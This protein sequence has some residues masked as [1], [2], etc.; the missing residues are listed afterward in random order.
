MHFSKPFKY[1][2]PFNID[3]ASP[4][5]LASPS[6]E[7]VATL[8]RSSILVR[9]AASLDIVRTIKLPSDLAG[10]AI[11]TSFLW[12]PSSTRVLVA[13]ADQVHVF[14]LS[15]GGFHGRAQVPH[16]LGTKPAL[17]C[18]GATDDEVCVFSP[19][20]L[21]LSIINFA[22]SKAVEIS[23]PKFFGV[24]SASRGFSFRPASR[25]LALLTRVAG[26][27]L[28]SIHGA[29][30]REM[31]RSWYPDTVDAQGLAW[32]PDG[33]W[34]IVWD[35]PAHGTR[36]LFHTPDG[37]VFKEWRGAH[38]QPEADDMNQYGP[39]VRSLASSPNSLYVAVA[40][41]ANR[42]C[43]LNNRLGEEARLHHTHIVE[44]KET[45]QIWQEQ[46]AP[47]AGLGL[48]A[49]VPPFIK[50]TQAVSPPGL[51]SSSPSDGRSGCSLI[52]FDSSSTLLASR[53]EEAPSTIWIW[54]IPTRELRAVLMFH[55]NITKAEWHP[56]L[57]E[58]LLVRCEGE[59]YSGI[60]FVWDPLSDGP[61]PIDFLPHLS[62]KRLAGRT[63]VSW[64]KTVEEPAVL[65]LT[66]H[67]E[68]ILT[69]LADGDGGAKRL[70]WA[71]QN[72]PTTDIITT[73][74]GPDDG[75]STDMDGG[76]SELDD[77]FHFKKSP[78]T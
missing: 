26:K 41:G 15:A 12:S 73:D 42:I 69:S 74:D 76:V 43:I 58:L 68:C 18:F 13:L 46:A 16:P 75:Y 21:K 24:T 30:T 14:S 36:V 78:I 1:I 66:D 35:S 67:Q 50:A 53:L 33:K 54:D 39:G 32:T 48:Q 52:K 4:H 51:S 11:V 8:L 19:V 40:D 34:L 37:H 62:S 20:G 9:A 3:T 60:A 5:C 23:N 45:L 64:L 49:Q 55:A 57:P 29:E 59:A 44:P 47:S 10:G 71:Q 25:H 28:I 63:S 70:P 31:Q 38:P 17:T 56:S 7:Y 2:D 27:D 22:A 65:F 6:G 77:T 61:R 72:P